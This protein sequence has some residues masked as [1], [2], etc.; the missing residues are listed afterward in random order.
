MRVEV[1]LDGTW[2]VRLGWLAQTALLAVQAVR[3]D[4]FP[5]WSWAGSLNL[6]VWLVVGAY[7]IWGCKPR[8]RLLGLTVMPLAAAL[9][10]SENADYTQRVLAALHEHGL[11]EDIVRA[12]ER[13][14]H[15]A[16]RF[17]LS[18]DHNGLR[19][20]LGYKG[21]LWCAWR[22]MPKSVRARTMPSAV[23]RV[24]DVHTL[25]QETGRHDI[26][27]NDIGAVQ[28]SLQ[29]PIVCD[30]YGDNPAT[31]AFVLIDEA[32]NH[33]VAAGMIRAYA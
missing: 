7:L 13:A 8:Y 32:T 12:A 27:L 11:N 20:A 2:G 3:A 28:I 5:W 30:T 9:L 33:T 24:L 26:R 29:K 4:G 19:H 22:D 10:P 6:I 17:G 18:A 16:L 23:D 1:D 14:G 25:S 31:G 21:C 15:C